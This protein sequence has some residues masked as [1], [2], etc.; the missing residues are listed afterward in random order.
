[1]L[2]PGLLTD[3][4]VAREVYDFSVDATGRIL[5]DDNLGRPVAVPE[6]LTRWSHNRLAARQL[7]DY[8]AEERGWFWCLERDSAGYRVT[9][10]VHGR[11][12][13]HRAGV[14]ALAICGAALA[15]A[16][17]DTVAIHEQAA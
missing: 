3:L 10:W 2:L 4:R 17:A 16:A 12:Y 14:E 6:A 1:M 11:P 9:F 7:L 8:C 5:S 13:S 15:A